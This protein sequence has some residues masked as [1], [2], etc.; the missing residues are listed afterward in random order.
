MTPPTTTDFQLELDRIFRA[1]QDQRLSHIDVVSGNLHRDLGDILVLIM[2]RL[3]TLREKRVSHDKAFLGPGVSLLD[4]LYY[5]AHINSN[6]K[7]SN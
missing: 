3:E 6:A 7:D 2:T 1:A 4:S 5:F